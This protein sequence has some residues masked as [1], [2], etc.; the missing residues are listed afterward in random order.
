MSPE[1]MHQALTKVVTPDRKNAN[2]MTFDTKIPGTL[3]DAIMRYLEKQ[4]SA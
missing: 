4:K 2:G 3:I 1:Q